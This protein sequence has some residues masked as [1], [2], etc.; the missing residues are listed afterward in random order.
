MYTLTIIVFLLTGKDMAFGDNLGPYSSIQ[1]CMERGAEL[2]EK[3]TSTYP[4]MSGV[5]GVAIDCFMKGQGA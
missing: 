3:F 2:V 5:K 4:Y 1:T